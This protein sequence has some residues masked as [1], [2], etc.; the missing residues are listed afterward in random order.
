MGTS[1]RFLVQ[2]A[3]FFPFTIARAPAQLQVEGLDLPCIPRFAAGATPARP[4]A[5][6]NARILLGWLRLGEH[7]RAREV[8]TA[9]PG[10]T[11]RE[12]AAWLAAATYWYFRASGDLEAIR[13]VVPAFARELSLPMPTDGARNAFAA[14]ALVVHGMLCCGGL[15]AALTAS[16]SA[17]S[18]SGIRQRAI[19]RW[20]EVERQAWQPGRGHFRPLLTAGQ[21]VPPEVADASLLV[22]ASA[23]LLL[24]SG[25]RFARHLRAV[26]D[27][28]L[29]FPDARG[30]LDPDNAALLLGAATQ[31]GDHATRRAAWAALLATSG[32]EDTLPAD[33]A[34]RSRVTG[35]I[36]QI[37]ARDAT[38]VEQ[39]LAG[40]RAA[41]VKVEDL[42][43]GR[44]DLEDVFLAIMHAAPVRAE[45]AV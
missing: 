7:D 23:G 11:N 1:I 21:I 14:E 30:F 32:C 18:G 4:T 37:A 27:D 40:L 22:P 33:R 20:L 15:E 42:E 13:P 35:R 3:L 41:Q 31:L 29:A 45:V 26:T 38:E 34:A 17:A 2:F 6:A 10:P 28:A 19:E 25:D 5:R 43:I 16:P 44:A 39:V 8:L 9:R 36:A 12:E 24:A